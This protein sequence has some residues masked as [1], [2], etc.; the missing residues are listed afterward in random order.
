ML[1]SASRSRLQSP[2][3][4]LLA[5]ACMALLAVQIAQQLGAR[6]LADGAWV[7]M[8]YAEQFLERGVLAFAPGGRGV[9]G[10]TSPGFVTVVAPMRLLF[11]GDAARALSASS[12][13]SGLLFVGLLGWMLGSLT[14]GAPRRRAAT[15]ALVT[16]ALAGSAPAL[17]CHFASGV[18]TT[19]ALAYLTMWLMFAR[20]Q[21]RRVTAEAALTLGAFGGMAFSV[22]PDLLLFTAGVPLA[23]ALLSREPAPR[24]AWAVALGA[25]LLAASMQSALYAWWMH[26]ALPLPLWDRTGLHAGGPGAALRELAAFAR[27][28]WPLLVVIGVGIATGPA[29]W[30]T[31]AGAFERALLGAAAVFTLFHAAALVPG[32]TPAQRAYPPLLPVLAYVAARRLAPLALH[33]PQPAFRSLAVTLPV[34]VVAA[35]ALGST[36]VR[37]WAAVGRQG[38]DEERFDAGAAYRADWSA[39]WVALD[40]VS[41]LADDLTIATTDVGMPL[42]LSSRRRIVDLTGLHEHFLA[43]GHRTADNLLR[44]E[45][46]DLVYLPPARLAAMNAALHADPWFVANYD[47]WPAESLRAGTGVAVRRDGPHTETLRALFASRA[48]R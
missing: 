16:F 39:H 36:A 3:L 6:S 1:T 33:L 38:P 44:R 13:V 37:Q 20:W 23:A 24:R 15:F 26:S 4:W 11:G 43:H 30:W 7:F 8:R 9:Y 41:N 46:P 34:I 45:R 35:L 21:A 29:R 22:R 18:E 47:T 5:S 32:L 25:T 17:A 40:R 2:L 19:Y 28:A 48:A 27:G 10:L 14:S 12:V 31:G 42:A